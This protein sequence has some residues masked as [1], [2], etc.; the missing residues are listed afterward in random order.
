MDEWIAMDE[1]VVVTVVVAAAAADNQQ[2]SSTS[3]AAT[4]SLVTKPNLDSAAFNNNYKK[5]TCIP[6][7]IFE[8]IFKSTRN[9][10]FVFRNIYV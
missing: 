7:K 3:A 6:Q 10:F 5:K 1:T 4:W 8:N 2:P 9:N